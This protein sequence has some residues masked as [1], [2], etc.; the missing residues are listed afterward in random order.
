MCEPGAGR[1]W[2]TL[3]PR[4]PSPRSPR[5]RSPAPRPPGAL[6]PSVM[7]VDLL[8]GDQVAD[9]LDHAADLRPVRLHDDVADPPQAQ[10]AQRVPL[11]LRAADPRLDLGDPQLGHDCS[12]SAVPAP[13]AAVAAAAARALSMAAGA[14]CSMGRARRGAVS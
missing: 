2:W 9:R 10:R 6:L 13:A 1:R 8:D 12:R 7:S 4:P 14:T 3:S 5:P 11:H